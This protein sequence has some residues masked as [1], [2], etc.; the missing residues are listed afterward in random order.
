M[1]ISSTWAK[2]KG[3]VL[4]WP[5]VEEVPLTGWRAHILPYRQ[6]SDW[7]GEPVVSFLDSVYSDP[8]RYT[9]RK[10]D[11]SQ[12]KGTIHEWMEKDAEWSDDEGFFELTDQKTGHVYQAFAHIRTVREVLD[13]PFQL[14]WWESEVLFR[15]LYFRRAAACM[16][17]RDIA[18]NKAERERAA[19]AVTEKLAREE[20]ARRFR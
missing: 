8:K 13:L 19:N 9:I 14:T 20:F 15:A 4:N 1:S 12:Y 11:V 7:I 18:R 3:W 5:T 17:K 2:F 16:R 6:N 10:I